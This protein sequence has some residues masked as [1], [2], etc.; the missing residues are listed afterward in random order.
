MRI[1][2]KDK[3]FRY[4]VIL[5]NYNT[6][7]DAVIAASSVVENAIS[8]DYIICFIDGCSTKHHQL[9]IFTSANIHN[10]CVLK[11]DENVG[12]A[13]GNNAGIRYLSERYN[14][15]HFVIMNP[16]VEIRTK[17]LIDSL[18]ECLSGLDKSYC[19][20]QPL[21]WTPSISD[22]PCMQTCIR[23]VYSYFDCLLDSFLP[24]RKLFI[25]KYHEMIYF[26]ERPY[27]QFVDFEVPS[28]CFF[29]IKADIF[30][31]TGLFDERTFLFAEEIILGYKLK[32]NGYK[33]IL[34]P[35]FQV[36]HE[37]GKSTGSHKKVVN[38]FAIK[39][40][41]KALDVYLRYYLKCGVFKR[42][43]VKTLFRVNYFCK[44]SYYSYKYLQL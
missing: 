13:R 9:E 44:K 24:V 16:D 21:I 14:I 22:N 23:K 18:I 42:K 39:E 20:I 37:G 27:K 30:Y 15:A 41:I 25:E 29:I 17:G 11:L 19:G 10:T 38:S 5:L 31:S 12:Y 33:F 36:I 4:A 28:G 2:N 35:N 8:D 26:K 32:Q 7:E 34:N 3:S 1:E 6:A 43:I 40:E